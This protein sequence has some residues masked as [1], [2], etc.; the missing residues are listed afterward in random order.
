DLRRRVSGSDHSNDQ[1]PIGDDADELSLGIA[2]DDGSH[3]V[4]RHDFRGVEGG[5]GFAQGLWVLGHD[6]FD[7]HWIPFLFWL[8]CL[9]F[10][11]AARRAPEHMPGD[12][13]AANRPRVRVA[14]T[15]SNPPVCSTRGVELRFAARFWTGSSNCGLMH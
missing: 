2:Y 8:A 12:A 13:P 4:A 3:L 14:A 1:V 15:E 11:F 7:F 6:V 9:F 10:S 5:V